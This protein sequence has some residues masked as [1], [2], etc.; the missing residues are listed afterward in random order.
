MHRGVFDGMGQ[1][2]LH[3]RIRRTETVLLD[4][5]DVRTND[6]SR[7]DSESTTLNQHLGI[8]QKRL[9]SQASNDRGPSMCQ[10]SA[11]I[12]R[13]FEDGPLCWLEPM[14]HGGRE[15]GFDTTN[16]YIP[17]YKHVNTNQLDA[18][19]NSRETRNAKEESTS[20]G[21]FNR[22]CITPKCH[23]FCREHIVM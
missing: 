14:C 22:I 1:Q 15:W 4:G 2:L 5:V 19:G 8:V 17:K 20:R 23:I 10:N 21:S 11:G 18:M 3:F 16:G 9:T 13:K 7:N 12:M 6:R